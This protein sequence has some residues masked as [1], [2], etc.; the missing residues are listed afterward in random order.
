MLTNTTVGRLTVLDVSAGES[1]TEFNK[2]NNAGWRI[3]RDSVLFDNALSL[4]IP[5][6]R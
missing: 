2:E 6:D 4:F 5:Y 1:S 3:L